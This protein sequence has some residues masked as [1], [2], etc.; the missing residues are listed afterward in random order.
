MTIP[1]MMTLIEPLSKT[2][3]VIGVEL[4]GHG[5]SPDTD[6]PLKFATLA[7]DIA[8]LIDKLGVGQADVAGLSFGGDVAIRTAIQH[9]KKV[10][11]LVVVSTGYARNGW[12]PEAREGM[13]Q[14]SAAFA[15]SML[16]NT[17]TGKFSR[18][19]PEP[20]R[21]P[22]FL[23]RMG[24]LL[25][26]DYDNASEIKKLPMPVMLV[27]TDHDSVSQQHIA[28]FYG[29]LGGG[30]S[31]PGWQN[32]KFTKARLAVIP[33]YSHYNFI[34]SPEIAPLV[35]KFLAVADLTKGQGL[36]AAAA[37]QATTDK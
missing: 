9:P 30:I 4:Q 7:D 11:R 21:F 1:E 3:K 28:E 17:P 27:F 32:T 25:G 8:A 12:F 24:K 36:G 20:N 6:R 5:R 31:E 14:V 18:E 33:G 35:E 10:R 22:K 26:E 16:P 23:D 34:T 15:E 2:R 29:L 37:S 19:W 13:A